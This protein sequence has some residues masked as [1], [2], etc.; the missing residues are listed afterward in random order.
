MIFHGE[1]EEIKDLHS[2]IDEWTSK[3]YQENK[4]GHGWLGNVLHGAGL[5]GRVNSETNQLHCRG[6]ITYLGDVEMFDETDEAVFNLNTETAW[7]PMCLM[8]SAVIDAMKYKSIG[9][10]YC[11]EEPGL[12]VYEVYDPYGDFRDKYY[13]DI[14]VYGEDEQNEGLMELFDIRDYCDDDDLRDAL[15]S[16]LKSDE[17]D[18][19]TLIKLAENYKFENKDTYLYIHEYK[20]VDAPSC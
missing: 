17:Q 16:F 19:K 5:G 12:E 2:K 13:I 15:Q 10:S 6:D 9:F 8:W 7:S 14:Y 18:M 3:N 20:F 1:K 4:F 11:A